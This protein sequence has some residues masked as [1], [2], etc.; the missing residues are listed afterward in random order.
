MDNIATVAGKV[1]FAY[2]GSTPWHKLGKRVPSMTDPLMAL[3]AANLDWNVNRQ[4]IFLASGSV[5]PDYY[6]MVRDVDSM[7]LG[8]V[9][10]RYTEIQNRDAIMV[11]ES[12]CQRHGV[13]IETLGALGNGSQVFA[14]ARLPVDTKVLDG[15]DVRG[16]FL[17]KWAH[18]GSASLDAFGTPIRVVCQNTLSMALSNGKAQIIKLRHTASAPERLEQADKLVATM[19]DAMQQTGKTFTAMAQQRMTAQ[20]VLAFVESV[21]P[22]PKDN[23]V[24][25]NLQNRRD[26]VLDLVKV[27]MGAEMAGARRDGST[28]VW[29]AYNAVTEYVDH[30]RTGASK[31]PGEA[32]ES[33][34]FG[35]GNLMK[36]QALNV[37]RQLVAA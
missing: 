24:S 12:A 31:N 6:A 32:N 14:L 5:V 9:G 7:S 36:V 22:T 4:P 28:T 23:K 25:T 27:G 15:D 2:Q 18:D 30:V 3:Q 8:V 13:T 19:I 1:Q 16:Y 34:L 26:A 33:A 20:Q 10:S 11:L 35:T 21:F 17:L 37:A 29:G